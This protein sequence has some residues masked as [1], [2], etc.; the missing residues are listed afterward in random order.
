MNKMKWGSTALTCLSIIGVVGTAISAAK[1]QP[2][3]DILKAKAYREKGEPLTKKEEIAAVLPAYIPTIAIG[4]GTIACILGNGVLTRKQQASFANAYA[5]L[6]RSYKEYKHK[7]EELYGEGTDEMVVSEIAD[8]KYE[9]LGKDDLDV[10]NGERWFFDSH[11]LQYFKATLDEV[12]Q[13]T[14]MGDGMECYLIS[15][16][17]DYPDWFEGCC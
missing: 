13:K 11:T 6:D 17:F 8:D 16:P 5:L 3:A 1:A 2:K 15:T 10:A 9:E 12:V 7:V 4:A 14:V